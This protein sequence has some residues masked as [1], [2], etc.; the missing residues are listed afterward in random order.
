MTF[1][2][3]LGTAWHMQYLKENIVHERMPNLNSAPQYLFI[4]ATSIW[5]AK[6]KS[7]QTIYLLRFVY[8]TKPIWKLYRQ[9]E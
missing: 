8:L 5:V 3:Y 6:K 7:D 2:Y 1:V 4:L 9:S